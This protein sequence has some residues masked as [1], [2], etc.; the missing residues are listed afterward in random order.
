ML[1]SRG[2]A[3]V[4]KGAVNIVKPTFNLSLSSIPKFHMSCSAMGLASIQSLII[5]P[6]TLN[7]MNLR[8]LLLKSKSVSDSPS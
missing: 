7:L 1:G 2:L 8:E 5:N 6:N 4:F 3:S